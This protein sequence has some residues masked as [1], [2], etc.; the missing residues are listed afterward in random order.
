M[1]KFLL[2]NK[3]DPNLPTRFNKTVLDFVNGNNHDRKAAMIKL[4][5]E[6]GAKTGAELFPE[7]NRPQP[8]RVVRTTR[9]ARPAV[10]T[11]PAR[12][13]PATLPG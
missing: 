3:A 8:A 11:R 4:L 5:E 7:A 13:A 10:T 1:M 2:A 9:P 12:P 6:H